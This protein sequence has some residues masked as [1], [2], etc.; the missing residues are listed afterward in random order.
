MRKISTCRRAFS[1]TELLVTIA[2]ALTLLAVALP[3]V[4]FSLEEGRVREASRQIN[5]FLAKAKAQSALTGRPHGVIFRRYASDGNR[6][7]E[8]SLAEIPAPFGGATTESRVRATGGAT[9]PWTVTFVTEPRG[10]ADS[11]STGILNTM[12]KTGDRFAIRIDYK[13]PLYSGTVTGSGYQLDANQSPAPPVPVYNGHPYQLYRQP[14]AIHNQQLELPQSTY[15]ALNQSG[16]GSSISQSSTTGRDFQ[17]TAGDM[18]PVIMMF[19]PS[20]N[21]SSV[22]T[23]GSHIEVPTATAHFLVVRFRNDKNPPPP[24]EDQTNLWVSVGASAGTITTNDNGGDLNKNGTVADDE[25]R[26]YAVRHDLRGGR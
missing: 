8:L 17:S 23:R 21:V 10:D 11:T 26:Y 18:E 19:G 4:K 25:P 15:I 2:I 9:G 16:Y 14:Q 6:C 24:I 22:H 13:G 12:L 5:A 20:G 3:M 1:L 7:T